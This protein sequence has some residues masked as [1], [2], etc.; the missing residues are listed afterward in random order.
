MIGKNF[1]N[2]ALLKIIY[3]FIVKGEVMLAISFYI[4]FMFLIEVFLVKMCWILSFYQ[5]LII[6]ISNHFN[7]IKIIYIEYKQS[8]I[9]VLKRPP[10]YIV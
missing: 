2:S 5:F 8:H 6:Y 7:F 9:L 4:N 3:L 1:S 10:S